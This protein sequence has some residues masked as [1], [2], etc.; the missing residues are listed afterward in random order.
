AEGGDDVWRDFLTAVHD[1]GY[2]GSVSLECNWS[3]DTAAA[4]QERSAVAGAEERA[5]HDR[6]EDLADRVGAG[7]DLPRVLL[8]G[9]ERERHALAVQVFARVKV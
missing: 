4:E 5:G 7:E 8:R 1:G 3:R 9:L 2:R 6:S